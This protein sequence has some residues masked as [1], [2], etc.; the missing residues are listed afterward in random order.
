[1]MKDYVILDT[2]FAARVATCTCCVIVCKPSVHKDKIMSRYVMCLQR[3]RA[4]VA[5]CTWR[6][7]VSQPSVQKD[8]IMSRYILQICISRSARVAT[9]TCMH[10]GESTIST[11]W[12]K[13][14]RW[15]YVWVATCTC[16]VIV[17]T[18]S[19]KRQNKMIMLCLIPC[20]KKEL[21]RAP[22]AW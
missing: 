6:M 8:K 17:C 22:V 15:C 3:S 9:C 11:K 20:L 10:V 1:M 5:T 7:L 4:R 19:T 21:L 18:L 12:Q 13:N 14:K 16:C 2:M